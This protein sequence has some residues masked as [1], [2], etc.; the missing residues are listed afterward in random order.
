MS[1]M[2][3]ASDEMKWTKFKLG[4]ETRNQRIFELFHDY[5]LYLKSTFFCVLRVNL[6]CS[7]GFLLSVNLLFIL[8]VISFDLGE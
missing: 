7:R 5:F 6:A 3:D 8:L 1:R 4:K 2:R